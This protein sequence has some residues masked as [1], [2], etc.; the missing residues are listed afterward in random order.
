MIDHARMTVCHP[1]PKSRATLATDC[2]SRPTPRH[3][4]LRA[5]SVNTARPAIVSWTSVHV[6]VGHTTSRQCQRRLRHRDLAGRPNTSVSRTTVSRRPFDWRPRHTR[7]TS[8]ARQ[9]FPRSTRPRPQ[10]HVPPAPEKVGQSEHDDI[11]GS[12]LGIH[13]KPPVSLA[14]DSFEYQGASGIHGA[15]SV[16][17]PSALHDEE[18]HI[19]TRAH[20]SVVIGSPGLPAR[21]STVRSCARC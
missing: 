5:R 12:N 16:T 19:P 20:S 17:A 7:G 11:S 4:F 21:R 2:P 15:T 10:P 18:P 3:A 1:T 8:P 6:L 9:S 13:L 14:F